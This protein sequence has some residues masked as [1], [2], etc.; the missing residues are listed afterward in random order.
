M[1]SLKPDV[2]Y[3]YERSNGVIYSRE[4]GSTHRKEIG[5]EYKP[6]IKV[7]D[8]LLWADVRETAKDHPALQKILDNAIIM[9]RLIKDN[10]A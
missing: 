7:S 6:D 8:S 10:P 1:G 4:L 9:Y 2:K 3:I 5:R